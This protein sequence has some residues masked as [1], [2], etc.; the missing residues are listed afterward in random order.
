MFCL[1]GRQNIISVASTGME[2]ISEHSEHCDVCLCIHF[3]IWLN[4]KPFHSDLYPPSVSLL[5]TVWLQNPLA[6]THQAH[7]C[8]FHF[9]LM[10]ERE[11]EICGPHFWILLVCFMF[12]LLCI[13]VISVIILK[14][15]SVYLDHYLFRYLM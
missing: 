13:S 6:Q 15:L 5:I 12:G 11:G 9:S 2:N 1:N 14:K 4:Q 8:A 7:L 3:V 10:R